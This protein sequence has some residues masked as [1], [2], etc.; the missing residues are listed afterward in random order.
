MTEPSAPPARETEPVADR[1]RFPKEYGVPTSHDAL[2]PWSHVEKRLAEATVYWIATCTPNGPPRVRPVDGLYLDGVIYV[3]GSPETGWA[4]DL[5]RDRR[6]SVHLDGPTDIVI[7]E[8]E[9]ELLEHGPGPGMAERLV[10]A[11]NAK[12]PQY[13]MTAADYRG[14]GPFAIRPSKVLAWTDFAKDPTRFRFRAR[15]PHES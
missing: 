12:Y 11:S 2:L 13:G 10:A 7:V 8:G 9:A 5:A 3:G 15:V 14:P 4:R 1:P 6:V